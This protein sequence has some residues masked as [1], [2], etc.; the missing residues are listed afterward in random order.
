L[1]WSLEDGWKEDAIIGGSAKLS[2]LFASHNST[3]TSRNFFGTID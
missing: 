1:A 3:T 2:I